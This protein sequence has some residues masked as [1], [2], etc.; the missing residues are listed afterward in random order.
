MPSVRCCLVL[1]AAVSAPLFF[2]ADL[3][4]QP[5]LVADLNQGGNSA[6]Q[7]VSLFDP[8][9][10]V[11]E[12]YFIGSDPA[13]GTEIWRTDGSSGGTARVSDV[14]PGRCG[15]NPGQPVAFKEWI[16]FAAEDGAS[17]RELWQSDG[18][19]GSERPLVDL[20]PGP[21]SSAPQDLAV[22]GDRL[23]FTIETPE[24]HRALWTSDGTA[25]GTVALADFGYPWE[26][27]FAIL[28]G[29]FRTVGGAVFF[30]VVR[31]DT[32]EPWRSDGT[33]AGTRP[34]L[35]GLGSELADTTPITLLGGAGYFWSHRGLWRTDGTMAGTVKIKS[36]E[37]IGIPVYP[38]S[39]GVAIQMAAWN[40]RLY[41]FGLGDSGYL[42]ISDGTAAGTSRVLTLPW[43]GQPVA[44]STGLVFVVSEEEGKEAL[45]R[46]QGT[47]GPL[48]TIFEIDPGQIEYGPVQAG[49]RAYFITQSWT[50]DSRSLWVTDGTAA[51]TRTVDEGP[52]GITEWVPRATG[53]L[54]T[55]SS[56]VL[57]RSRAD[58]SGSVAL[59]DFEAG[60]GSSGPL[61]QAVLGGRLVFSA[62]TA[63]K[64]A[65]L[66][67]S[68]GTPEGTREINPNAAWA[69]QL[70]T[71]GRRLVFTSEIHGTDPF[72]Y[73]Q[74]T[75]NGIWATD[76]TP[77]GTRQL[78]HPGQNILPPLMPFRDDVF[79]GGS[80]LGGGFN[81]ELWRTTGRL[82][83]G[84]LVKNI[85][86]QRYA[87]FHGI[88]YTEPSYPGPGVVI[89]DRLVFAANDGLNGREPWITD[90]T[91]AGTHL[92]RDINLG[93]HESEP[94]GECD[95][96]HTYGEPS[97]PD[98]FLPFRHGALFAADDGRRG[99]ELWWTD[100]TAE[101][102]RRVADV[103]PGRL[104]SSPRELTLFR[105]AAWFLA[106]GRDG[107]DTLWRSDG[108]APGTFEIHD[109]RLDGRPSWASGLTAAGDKLFFVVYN[110]ATGSE[111]WV[112]GGDSRS[113]GLVTEIRPG[114]AGSYPQS[115]TAVGDVLLFA[116]TDGV[117]GLEAWRSDGTAAGTRR[118][119][120][121]APG[122]DAAS[123]GPFSR[124]GDNLLT[125]ADDGVHGR[126]LW[127]IPVEDVVRP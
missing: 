24:Q 95:S 48:E 15:S 96:R 80:F 121:I 23:L 119:T 44:L 22:W 53:E 68:D 13:H 52:T 112:S 110:P 70:V 73:P 12:Y 28:P 36:H 55:T 46:L 14:C 109:L 89:G 29:S 125:G 3:A 34:L 98:G 115:L 76:G 65:P 75:P 126:E 124:V 49:D 101:G 27:E 72:G 88:C 123:P 4:A 122:P 19:P 114:N 58:G 17:G 25:E 81:V 79:Y 66:F 18:T 63:A 11:P 37:E 99:R 67:V 16:W 104:G 35:A 31:E 9:D 105:G 77:G 103:L 92:L 41:A 47:P 7:Q 33:A 84:V 116:A 107:S 106:T 93:R 127:A 50:D 21:C 43:S 78:S 117:T 69:S 1:G 113:T 111:L 102:T 87:G 82:Q 97:S 90:G 62:Q 40:G 83:G 60:P 100:G 85:N 57:R 8:V 38:E 120:D 59:R 30:N 64:A 10:G 26:A 2:A 54:Y 51:G 5:R 118:L 42:V 94:D 61:S 71:A 20:C 74:V 91:T 39:A 32:F 45:M 108:T 56:G 6:P 86:L